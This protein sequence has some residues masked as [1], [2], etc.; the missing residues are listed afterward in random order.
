MSSVFFRRGDRGPAVAEIRARLARLGMLSGSQHVRE[1]RSLRTL[2]YPAD[3]MP[4]T[5]DPAQWETTALASGEFDE[6]VDEEPGAEP[7]P[8]TTT[9]SGRR[10]GKSVAASTEPSARQITGMGQPQ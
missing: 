10:T 9:S 8:S 2:M 1:E 6:E 4:D 7:L 3:G 5:T